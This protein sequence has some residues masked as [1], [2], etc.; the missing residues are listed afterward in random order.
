MVQNITYSTRRRMEPVSNTP[1]R[2]K[3]LAFVLP[4]VV[5]IGLLGLVSLLKMFGGPFWIA[6]PQ[7]WIYPLQTLV[8][9]VVLIFFWREYE[10]RAPRQ[11]FLVIGIALLVFVLWISPQQF[12]GFGPRTDGFNP[13]EFSSQSPFYWP[14][15]LMRFVRL[16]IV[17]PLV[18]EIFWRGFLLRFVIDEKFDQVSFGAFSVLSFAV[19]T[20]GFTFSHSMADWPAAAATSAL[21]NFIAYRTRSLSSCVLAHA[22]TNFALG[23]WIMQTRQWG[24]W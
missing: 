9:G 5:F 8:C 11:L 19:V 17:V 14:T 16:V 23:L 15:I 13:N 2:R 10:L 24:F 7:Y 1:P 4:M 18:E 21:Y 6:S 12:F 22:I 3:L 20:L